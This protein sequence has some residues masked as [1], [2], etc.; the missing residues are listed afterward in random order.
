[1][2]ETASEMVN[3]KDE[4]KYNWDAKFLLAEVLNIYLISSQ[5][6]KEL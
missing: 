2:R 3:T 5:D 1:M 4:D 6:R